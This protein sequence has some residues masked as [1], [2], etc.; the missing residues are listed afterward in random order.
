MWNNPVSQ[1]DSTVMAHIRNL[2]RELGDNDVSNPQYI[3]TKR[4]VGY[5][6]K[7]TKNK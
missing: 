5:M 7:C 3:H 1:N 4:G 6:F 2:R